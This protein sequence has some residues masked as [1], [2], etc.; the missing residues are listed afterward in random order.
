MSSAIGLRRLVSQCI[1]ASARCEQPADVV[2]RLCA[3]QAQDYGQS[4]W[5]IGAR[6]RASTVG[7]VERAIEERAILRTW[8]VRG[9]IHFVLPGDV[10]WLLML[11]AP[12][13]VAA[14]A[15]RGAQ[16][17]LS[18]A[19]IDRCAEL[20]S[21][22]LSGDRRLARPDVFRLFAAA[23]IE[24]TGQR[25]YHI[26]VRL[27]RSGL[28]CLGPMQG[29]QPTIVLLDDWAPRAAARD[30]T[31]DEAIALLASR[32]AIGRGPVTEQDLARW[33]GVPVADAARGLRA[34]DALARRT[35]DGVEYWLAADQADGPAPSAG[36][37]RTYLLAGFDEF[38]LGYKDRADVIDDADVHDVVPGANG[39]FR[40]L[41]V[42]GGRIVG[43][44][45]RSVRRDELTLS[46]RPFGAQAGGLERT[47]AA[48]ANRYRAFLDL[49]S[50]TA[51]VVRTGP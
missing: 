24:T 47:V 35:L 30:L 46:L 21:D 4:L 19:Q 31:R 11:A 12:R 34:A 50:G 6:L 45:S 37:G 33:A 48:E 23:G 43:T 38:F 7:K 2:H 13:L 1:A 51:P 9:T 40:P 3:V 39:V 22:V 49:P 17:G 27:A 36:R 10:R 41:I 15:R 25:G 16:L 5:A 18:D 14:D 26:L 20:L 44:W 28:I 32:F 42:T 29:K 8:L